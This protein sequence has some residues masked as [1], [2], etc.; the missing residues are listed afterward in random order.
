VSNHPTQ[1]KAPVTDEGLLY[2]IC[3]GSAVADAGII[4]APPIWAARNEGLT[5]QP[6]AVVIGVIVAAVIA[7]PPIPHPYAI[8][9]VAVPS[10][11]KVVMAMVVMVI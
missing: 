8:D 3:S 4:A 7:G 10:V 11:V 6:P 5:A 2:A 9:E 1:Q